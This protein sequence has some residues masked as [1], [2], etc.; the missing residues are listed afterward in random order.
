M[1]SSKTA[2]IW[3]AV[4]YNHLYEVIV[5]LSLK[6]AFI[7]KDVWMI[8]NFIL[9]FPILVQTSRFKLYVEILLTSCKLRD[10]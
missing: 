10:E 7:D 9:I 8:M 3:D 4:R 5:C 2:H 6:E 1:G